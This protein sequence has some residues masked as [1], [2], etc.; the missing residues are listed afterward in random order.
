MMVG[1]FSDCC[2][3]DTAV[4]ISAE[5]ETTSIEDTDIDVG[6]ELLTGAV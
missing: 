3:A 5:G 1:L 4:G 6:V 2:E